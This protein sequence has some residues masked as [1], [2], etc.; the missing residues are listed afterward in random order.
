MEKK[1]YFNENHCSCLRLTCKAFGGDPIPTL[2]WKVGRDSIE[3][4][5]TIQGDGFVTSTLILGDLEI[6]DSGKTISC[7]AH[8]NDIY[9]SPSASVKIEIIVAPVQVKL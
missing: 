1:L 5:Q 3:Y 6:Q 4:P 8:N 7:E 9:P 2:K